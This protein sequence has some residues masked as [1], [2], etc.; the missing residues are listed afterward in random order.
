VFRPLDLS[1]DGYLRG[2]NE[3]CGFKAELENVRKENSSSSCTFSVPP[4]SYSDILADAKEEG[5]PVLPD[6][7]WHYPEVSIP[8][9]AG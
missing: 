3:A 2:D 6:S 8:T 9:C 4:I 1:I 5:R 7:G